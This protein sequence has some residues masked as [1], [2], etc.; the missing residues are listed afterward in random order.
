LSAAEYISIFILGAIV[1]AVFAVGLARRIPLIVTSR[2]TAQAAFM[3]FFLFLLT[4]AVVPLEGYLALGGRWPVD[5]F[6][7]LS[8]LA[9]VTAMFAAR[10]FAA[11]MLVSLVTLASAVI[12]GRFFCGWVC[13]LGTTFDV[14]DRMFFVKATRPEGRDGFMRSAKYLILAGVVVASAL[15]AQAA[16]WFDPMAIVTRSYAVSVLPAADYAAKAVLETPQG[17]ARFRDA[18]PGVTGGLNRT[19]ATLKS[20]NVLY[21]A[22]HYY[23][24]F[25]LF[26]AILVGLVAVQGYQKRFWCRKLCPLGAMLGLAGKWRPLG[27]YLDSG[28]CT[29]CGECRKVC[30]VG[31]I[32]DK[33]LSPEE[34]TFCGVCVGPCPVAALSVRMSAPGKFETAGRIVPGRRAFLAAAAGGIATAGVFS[35]NTERLAGQARLI[36]PPGGQDEDGFVGACVRCGECMKACPQ[37]ALHPAGFEAGLAGVWT[38]KIVPVIGYCDYNCLPDSEPVGN[39]CATVCPTGAIRRLS[40]KEKHA[41]RLGTAYLRT[42][43]CIPYVE[44]T[45]C[46]VC[47]E[48]CPVPEKALKNEIVDARDPATGQMMKLQQP[49]VDK[50]LCVGCGQCEN[51]CPLKGEK[52]IRVEPIRAMA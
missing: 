46:G 49:H 33:G 10:A 7:R 22:D 44:R 12:A 18:A 30:P 15:G 11:A 39:F 13:P 34:C 43:K 20:L 17:S 27:V 52:G 45:A 36:R 25:T 4:Q 42:D 1:I 9:A 41:T 23:V 40:P 28:K 6:V 24:Q 2:M 19:E 26:T 31:A 29:D 5:F 51:V 14:F 16:G 37:N 35:L 21:D 38:P 50:T 47:V 48:H 8:P 32:Q 3:L